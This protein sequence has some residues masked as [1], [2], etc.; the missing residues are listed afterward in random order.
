MIIYV[1]TLVVVVIIMLALIA[2]FSKKLLSSIISMGFVSLGVSGLFF[3]LQA[4]D[5]A[6]TEAAIGAGLSTAIFVIALKKVKKGESR[7]EE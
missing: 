7:D 3:F 1:A 2:V 6:I 4:P 5:V